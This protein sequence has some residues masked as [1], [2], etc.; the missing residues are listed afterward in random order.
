MTAADSFTSVFGSGRGK[1]SPAIPQPPDPL[2]A[3][4]SWF[5]IERSRGGVGFDE[6]ER[7]LREHN[8]L[9]DEPHDQWGFYG[10]EKWPCA[11]WAQRTDGGD[12]ELLGFLLLTVT[13]MDYRVI[14]CG[15]FARSPY[16][17]RRSS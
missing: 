2:A 14:D 11:V 1:G 8:P 6:V 4:F 13:D 10:Y 15:C 9:L 16:L 12:A 3:F 7:K 5:D 17:L